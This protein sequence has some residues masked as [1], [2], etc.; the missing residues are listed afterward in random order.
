MAHGNASRHGG[1]VV[2]L[3]LLGDILL[4]LHE[5]GVLRLWDYRAAVT[6]RRGES[7]DVLLVG[8]VHLPAGTARPTV[9]LHPDTYVNK[10][11]IGT[12]AGT[13]LIVNVRTGRVVYQTTI[14]AGGAAVTAL[15]QSPVVDVVGI[16]CADGTV[17]IQNL[18]LDARIVTFQHAHTTAGQ[19]SSGSGSG[20]VKGPAT[21]SAT[22]Y[23]AHGT[24]H[25][26]TKVTALS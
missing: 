22:T 4:S 14:H 25:G 17:A 1:A 8:E 16:G 11:V 7:T 3:L 23:A 15:A 6:L 26:G 12:D 21:T 2:Q 20:S 19:S 10:V 13:L 9:L 24:G 5:D 18:R